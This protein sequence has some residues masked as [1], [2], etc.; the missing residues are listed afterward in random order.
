MFR[1]YAC[2]FQAGKYMEIWGMVSE[3]MVWGG[4]RFQWYI[5]EESPPSKAA[6]FS[7]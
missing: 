5:M 6:V 3:G 2:Q 1:A 7:G 4:N